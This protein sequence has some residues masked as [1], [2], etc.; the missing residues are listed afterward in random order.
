MKLIQ[1]VFELFQDSLYN[2]EYAKFF[3]K[4]QDP[5]ENITDMIGFVPWFLKCN[6]QRYPYWFGHSDPR[7]EN[8]LDAIQHYFGDKG[9]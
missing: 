4:R 6:P 5:V 2:M 9:S 1:K 8:L 7:N 3:K